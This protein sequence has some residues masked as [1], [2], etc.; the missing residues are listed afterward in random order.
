MFPDSLLSAQTFA[1]C[2]G[3]KY[4]HKP[5]SLDFL[6]RI[7]NKESP[8]GFWRPPVPDTPA[9][10][11]PCRPSRRANS[12]VWTSQW[13]SFKAEPHTAFVGHEQYR[14]VELFDQLVPGRQQVLLF[15]EI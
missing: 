9:P 2:Q 5:H 8:P 12:D 11:C 14:L 15:G 3:A 6:S 1:S 13:T 7:V 4:L 10:T